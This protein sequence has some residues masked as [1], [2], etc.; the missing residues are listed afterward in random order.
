MVDVIPSKPIAYNVNNYIDMY[1]KLEKCVQLFSIKNNCPDFSKIVYSCKLLPSNIKKQIIPKNATMYNEWYDEYNSSIYYCSKLKVKQNNITVPT[2]S[3][4]LYRNLPIEKMAKLSVAFY[5]CITQ[6]EELKNEFFIVSLLGLDNHIRSYMYYDNSW[7]NI[8]TLSIGVNNIIS[9]INYKTS[10]YVVIPDT[11]KPVYIPNVDKIQLIDK[12]P[13]QVYVQ[14]I[15]SY[16]QL[17]FL[18]L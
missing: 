6:E 14:E 17:H 3:S 12:L 15:E 10:M 9:L 2:H 11:D 1:N 13:A 16:Q 8:S 5:L 7:I 4:D 18:K